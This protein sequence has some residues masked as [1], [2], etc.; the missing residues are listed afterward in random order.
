MV[1]PKPATASAS[2]SSLRNT[3][4]GLK[5]CR[6]LKETQRHRRRRFALRLSLVA[7]L[8]DHGPDGL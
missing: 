1:L 7:A 6:T 2:G 8:Y 4:G 5:A 3:S